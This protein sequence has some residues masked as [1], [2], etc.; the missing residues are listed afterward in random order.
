MIEK[1]KIQVENIAKKLGHEL[2]GW[3]KADDYQF[4]ACK[5]CGREV[6]ATNTYYAGCATI[7]KCDKR[8]EKRNA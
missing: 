6:K 8:L 5:N 1:I 7:Y 2:W 3:H 4:A